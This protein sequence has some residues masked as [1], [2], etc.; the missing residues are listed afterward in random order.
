MAGVIA[1]HQDASRWGAD[2]AAGVEVGETEAF[3]GESIDVWCVDSLLAVAAN[4]A[5][6]EVVGKD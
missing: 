1:G 3:C 6:A 2:G 4:I 5:V